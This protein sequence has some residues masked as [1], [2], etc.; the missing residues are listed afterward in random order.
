[1]HFQF[2]HRDGRKSLTHGPFER[3]I[4]DGHTIQTHEGGNILEWATY[5]VS[6]G[7]WSET[8]GIIG[9]YWDGVIIT[10]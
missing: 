8:K 7:M 10:S 5:D 4:I 3:V 2:T 9:E 1:M 6:L